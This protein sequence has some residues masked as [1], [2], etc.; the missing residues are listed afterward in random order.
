MLN[1]NGQP[2]CQGNPEIFQIISRRLTISI[3]RFSFLDRVRPQSLG[4][5]VSDI[6]T[7][8]APARKKHNL[9][10]VHTINYQYTN[11]TFGRVGKCLFRII[12]YNMVC[13]LL[14]YTLT[15]MGLQINFPFRSYIKFVSTHK[16]RKHPSLIILFI[17][18]VI[19]C[20][21]W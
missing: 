5:L 14:P 11:S 15:K 21:F 2:I 20:S 19:F 4:E 16:L 1:H 18:F 10:L 3:A 7:S 8:S 6:T 9:L 12:K 17:I 13:L